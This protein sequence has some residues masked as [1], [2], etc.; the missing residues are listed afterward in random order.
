MG[1]NLPCCFS[2]SAPPSKPQPSFPSCQ[3]PRGWEPPFMP[4]CLFLPI[5]LFSWRLGGNALRQPQGVHHPNTFPLQQL[6]AP[7]A[8]V[9]WL[10]QARSFLAFPILGQGTG[11]TL[12]ALPL[13]TCPC[14]LSPMG[15]G[16]GW[17]RCSPPAGGRLGSAPPSPLP[18][19]LGTPLPVLGWVVPSTT[20]PLTCPP[21]PR[22]PPTLLANSWVGSP[23]PALAHLFY[24]L[25]T[26]HW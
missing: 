20:A 18:C 12:G 4:F 25:T 15:D 13:G 2:F 19:P 5:P 7:P 24:H 8:L 26:C 16:G 10:T 9:L 6:P 17:G 22:Y 21:V 11:E 14:L 23:F 1:R 3:L